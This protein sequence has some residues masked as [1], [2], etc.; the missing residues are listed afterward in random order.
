MAPKAEDVI[1]TQRD[2]KRKLR[3]LKRTVKRDGN[4]HR[5][6]ALKRQMEKNPEEAHL[7]EEDLGGSES[8][9]LNALDRPVGE[10]E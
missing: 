4:K 1:V 2:D 7:A 5:R 3:I 10:A 6:N 9:G 8:K